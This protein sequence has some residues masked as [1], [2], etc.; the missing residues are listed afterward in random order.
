MGLKTQHNAL[1][2]STSYNQFRK[3]DL[4][5]K[6]VR[7]QTCLVASLVIFLTL[8]GGIG[9]EIVFAQ[10]TESVEKTTMQDQTVQTPYITYGELQSISLESG[11]G[12]GKTRSVK[13]RAEPGRHVSFGKLLF[14]SSLDKISQLLG[15]PETVD[16]HEFPGDQRLG[17]TL[18]YEGMTIE[19]DK[20]E[21][22]PSGVTS[23]QMCSSDW[24]LTV[25]GMRLHPGMS[26]DKLTPTVRESFQEDTTFDDPALDSFGIIH[27]AKP[28]S[29]KSGQ[30][31]RMQ[32]G[33][34][35]ITVHANDETRTIEMVRF[36]RLGP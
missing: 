27:I 35:Q 8:G 1:P 24:S 11:A 14:V 31:K 32:E 28:G 5:P 18:H 19:Y 4:R 23:I 16:R 33:K 22:G 10:T 2:V 6:L 12:S 21:G 7:K 15:E 30:V 36:A 34:A 17:A 3:M 26:V 25:G 29:G 9:P 13:S 20:Y